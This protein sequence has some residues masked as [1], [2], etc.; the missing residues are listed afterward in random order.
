MPGSSIAA[1]SVPPRPLRLAARL[2]LAALLVL[3]SLHALERLIVGPLVPV[4]RL[5]TEVL[6]REFVITDARL[7]HEGPNEVVSFRANLRAPVTIGNRVVYPFGMPG[8][9]TGW[10]QV[11]CTLGS[12]LQYAALLLIIALAWPARHPR[13]LVVRLVTSIVLAVV[14]LL[15]AVPTTVVAELRHIVETD[16]DSHALG[17]WMIWSRLLMGGGGV[18]L[19]ILFA[20]MAMSIGRRCSPAP[21]AQHEALAR[22]GDRHQGGAQHRI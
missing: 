6:D 20:V 3:V 14:L 18:A 5:V 16:V 7:D 2:L 15:V 22:G 19:S 9:P 4:F 21:T 10:Y 17:Y 12:V 1:A 8:V 13:E 11:D